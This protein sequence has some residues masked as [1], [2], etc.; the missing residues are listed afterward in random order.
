VLKHFGWYFVS[1][2][3]ALPTPHSRNHDKATSFDG[4]LSGSYTRHLPPS[5]WFLLFAFSI[6][7]AIYGESYTVSQIVFFI[8]FVIEH[9]ET[10]FDA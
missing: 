3:T 7:S 8:L 4:C 6:L 9:T 2:R 10:L 5:S 1:S